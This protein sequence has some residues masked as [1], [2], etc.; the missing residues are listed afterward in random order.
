MIDG[1]IK[2]ELI[3]GFKSLLGDNLFHKSATFSHYLQ[4]EYLIDEIAHFLNP[5][6]IENLGNGLIPYPNDKDIRYLGELRP[7]VFDDTIFELEP[8]FEEIEEDHHSILSQKAV[9][10]NNSPY[11]LGKDLKE[12]II[13]LNLDIQM[14]N[15]IDIIARLKTDGT[16]EDCLLSLFLHIWNDWL[17]ESIEMAE[18]HLAHLNH[19][20]PPAKKAMGALLATKNCARAYGLYYWG[21]EARFYKGEVVGAWGMMENLYNIL[22][23]AE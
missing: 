20:S 22:I 13:A 10:L 1:N 18:E 17:N 21:T 23:I 16:L 2:K 9:L 6:S 5:Q 19:L 12:A 4:D 3:C 8:I 14:S 11:I 15:S 7:I